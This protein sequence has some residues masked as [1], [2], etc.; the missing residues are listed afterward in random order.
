MSFDDVFI[1]KY[2]AKTGEQASLGL[3]V[4]GSAMSFQ[5]ALNSETES[6][7]EGQYF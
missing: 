6:D 4:D 3:H 7:I 5:I 2:S 1:V